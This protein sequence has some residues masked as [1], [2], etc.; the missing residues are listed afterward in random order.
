M[1]SKKV[2]NHYIQLVYCI[3]P[4][5]SPAHLQNI[6]NKSKLADLCYALS[7]SPA[8]YKNNLQFF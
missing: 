2:E 5:Q 1:L 8:T 7:S 6:V 4:V 3:H